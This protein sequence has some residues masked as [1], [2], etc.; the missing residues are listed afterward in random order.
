[1]EISAPSFKSW[2]ETGLT[3]QVGEVRTI[4]PVLQLGAVNTTVNVSAAQ[5]ALDLTSASTTAVV[6]RDTVTQTPLVGQN[7]YGLAALAPGVTG[8]GL[9]SGDNF[10]NQYGIQI[11]AAG[12]RQESNSFMIDGAPTR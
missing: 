11:N 5:A 7:V 9:T 8:P 12:Q 10:N 3:I 4:A 2:I 6:A 1:M